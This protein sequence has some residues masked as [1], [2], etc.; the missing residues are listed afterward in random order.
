MR[1][2]FAGT[3]EFSVPTLARLADSAHEVLAVYSQPDRPA[4]RGRQLRASPVK[5][6]ALELNLP[7]LQPSSLRDEHAA[8]QLA[9]LRPDVFVVVAYGLLLPQRILDIPRLGCINIHAS[10]LPRWRGAAPIQRAIEAGDAQS[11]VCIM[12]MEAGLDTGPV[13][14]TVTTPLA[15]DETGGSLHDRLSEMGAQAL[16]D[17]LPQIASGELIPQPQD[18]EAATY[19]HRLSKQEGRIDWALPAQVLS[20]RIRAF[21]PWP[22]A[23]AQ[24]QGTR[25]RL[26]NASVSPMSAPAEASPG[27]VLA[28]SADGIDV[29]TGEGVLRVLQLQLPGKRTL[30]AGEFLNATPLLGASLS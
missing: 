26:W 28:A 8:E 30:P 1:I 3:P 21:N 15:D 9:A 7:V 10:L 5:R 12:A 17:A 20:Q 24:Y 27:K 18:D 19:A 14:A 6:K 13:Y 23:Y 25:I 29:A 2:V 16:L 22:V 4:G 11:G